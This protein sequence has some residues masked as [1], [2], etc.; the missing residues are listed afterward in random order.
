MRHIR[1]CLILLGIALVGCGVCNTAWGGKNVRRFGYIQIKMGVPFQIVLYSADEAT[2][3]R[4]AQAAYRRLKQLNAILSDYDPESE[5]SRLC[6]LSGPNRPV[7]VS[8]E[9]FGILSRSNELSKKTGG[10]F[11]V[12]VGPV[13][14]LWRKSRRKKQLPVAQQLAES[15]TRVGH[16]AMVLNTTNKSVTLNK[17]QMQLDLGAIAKGYA[18]DEMIVVLSQH[19]IRTALID[20]SGDVTCQGAP[21]NSTGW[22]VGV[23]SRKNPDQDPTLYLRL[24]NMSVATSG[25]AHQA[26]VID[27]V[28]YS[29]IVDPKTGIGLTKPMTVSVIAPSGEQADSL[30]SAVSVMGPKR[31]IALIESFPHTATRIVELVDGKEIVYESTR[32]KRFVVAD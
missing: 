31:G 11:D 22:R 30:A 9:L 25:D 23:V 12:T 1:G 17:P 26:N 15:L 10:A 20:A 29:H 2:A 19:G 8:P 24:K 6:Q 16:S 21:P 3:N 7:S 14:K 5:L 32:W 4:A 27:G 18:A 28:R 13:V